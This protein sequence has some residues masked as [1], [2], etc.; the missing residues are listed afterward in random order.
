MKYFPSFDFQLFE[1][2]NVI[3]S[4]Q[5]IQKQVIDLRHGLLMPEKKNLAIQPGI[6]TT[7]LSSHLLNETSVVHM[8]W[9]L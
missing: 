8:S 9:P 1:N 4:L 7:S 5:T 6:C 3:L 2:E